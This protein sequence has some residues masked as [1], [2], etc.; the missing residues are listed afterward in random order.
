MVYIPIYGKPIYCTC[1]PHPCLKNL[2]TWWIWCLG[3][4][5]THRIAEP[6]PQGRRQLETFRE[7]VGWGI[8]LGF[9]AVFTMFSFF[10]KWIKNRIS[11]GISWFWAEPYLSQDDFRARLK[12]FGA[13]RNPVSPRKNTFFLHHSYVWTPN[14]IYTICYY[15]SILQHYLILTYL[16]I[17][18]IYIHIYI[19]THVYIY[20]LY[21]TYV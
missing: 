6:G 10:K 8:P 7:G 15:I 14:I 9:M 3:C 13:P 5:A 18:Y 21:M 19:Y 4:M 1:L 12:I 16:C 2:L 17:Y 20:I 11:Q